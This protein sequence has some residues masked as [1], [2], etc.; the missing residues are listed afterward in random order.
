MT[1]LS[2]A[3]KFILAHKKTNYRTKYSYVQVE[4][5]FFCMLSLFCAIPISYCTDHALKEPNITKHNGTT[6]HT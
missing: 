1:S 6:I 4:I 5:M 2:S 3:H